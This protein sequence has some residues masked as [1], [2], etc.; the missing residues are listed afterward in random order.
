MGRNVESLVRIAY[1]QD[2]A[3]EVTKDAIRDDLRKK[4]EDLHKKLDN[5]LNLNAKEGNE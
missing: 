5:L 4:S 3:L 2:M 1:N